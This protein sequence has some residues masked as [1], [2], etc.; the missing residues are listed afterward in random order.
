[1]R[2]NRQQARRSVPGPARPWLA[3]AILALVVL[4]PLLAQLPGTV[5]PQRPPFPTDLADESADGAPQL[6][7]VGESGVVATA[8]DPSQS[9]Y[10]SIAL[11]APTPT[12]GRLRPTAH[13]VRSG[14]SLLELADRFGLRPETVLWANNLP[15]PDLLVVGQKLTIPPVDGLL[16]KVEAGESLAGISLR[17]GLDLLEV[18]QA[19]GL[20]NP[21][22]LAAGV[23]LVLP[24]ARPV[25]PAN[26]L[27]AGPTGA[28][29]EAAL[30]AAVARA[31]LPDNVPELLSAGWVRTAAPNALYA[32]PEPGARQFT[33]LPDG[34][35]LER[36]GDLA[37]RRLP[38]RDPG[39]GRTRQAM[40]GWIEVDALEPARAPSPRE[41]PRAYPAD[42]RMDIFHAFVPYR[43]QLDGAAY[44]LANCGPTAIGMV[45]E[46]FGVRVPLSQLRKEVLDTQKIW[47]NGT[48]T[49]MTALAEVV[50]AHGLQTYGLREDGQIR[51]WTLEDVREQLRLR[52]PLVVQTYY[53]SLP[54][55]E[56]AAYYGDHY[57][58]VTGILDD[59]FL[60]NDPLDYDGVGWDRVMSGERLQRAMD[61]S[62]RRFAY[63]AFAAGP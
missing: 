24:G 63:A 59:G 29:L 30:A 35:R 52:R 58:V 22:E 36:T 51:R 46:G 32:G 48:G 17:H 4:A 14:E 44:S 15:D 27:A 13:V 61:A 16:Y 56:G 40:S 37:G 45:L 34:V 3:F 9:P 20:S 7:L 28:A 26:S 5:E 21:D 2:L 54:G 53:R 33:A 49:L 42:T 1:V 11:P 55:R 25:A 23:E 31:P 43:G 47:G 12:P 19:N 38:V 57:I 6:G 8:D 41:L 62:D 18:A 39:D 10:A 50:E 60:Y